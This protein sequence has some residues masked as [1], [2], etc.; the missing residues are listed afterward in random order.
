MCN[1]EHDEHDGP[2][3]GGCPSCN[4]TMMMVDKHY[5]CLSACGFQ[6]TSS[7]PKDWIIL[8]ML[9]QQHRAVREFFASYA[10]VSGYSNIIDDFEEFLR[11]NEH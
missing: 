9:I 6:A 4:G 7:N 1:T 2:M 10:A 5:T 3:T 8:H 11:K